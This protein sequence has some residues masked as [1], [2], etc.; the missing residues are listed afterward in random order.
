MLARLCLTLAA[1]LFVFS[2]DIQAQINDTLVYGF[3]ATS[4]PHG[5]RAFQ[6][7][8]R[9]DGR[10]EMTRMIDGLQ[11]REVR[12]DDRTVEW[13]ISE[14]GCTPSRCIR[15]TSCR[16]ISGEKLNCMEFDIGSGLVLA[17]FGLS[18]Y[19]TCAMTGTDDS[20]KNILRCEQ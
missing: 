13:V 6:I 15:R 20:G 2:A 14:R 1:A 11:I 4:S 9:A 5:L 19:R 10:F 7:L 18:K 12:V 3:W 17:G 8:T 16:R